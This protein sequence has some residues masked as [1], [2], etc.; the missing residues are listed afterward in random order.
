MTMQQN[1]WSDFLEQE[2]GTKA[3]YFSYGDQWG[4][5]QKQRNFY[6]SSFSD[7]YNQYLGTLGQQ[8]RQG[9]MP[10]G[11][12][13]PYLSNFDFNKYYQEQ[14]PYQTRNQGQSGFTPQV[15]WDVLGR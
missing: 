8:V 11:K 7:I 3:A 13:D 4:K 12:W 1:P 6:Q 14:V 2:P 9:L 15:Q 10:T 5:S